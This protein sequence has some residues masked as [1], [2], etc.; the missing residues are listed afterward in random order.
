M[1]I[2]FEFVLYCILSR[3]RKNVTNFL[4]AKAYEFPLFFLQ[5]DGYC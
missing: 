4:T 2:I 3:G 1:I 5:V